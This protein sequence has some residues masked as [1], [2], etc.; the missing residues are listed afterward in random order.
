MTRDFAPTTETKL[1]QIFTNQKLLTADFWTIWHI[2]AGLGLLGGTFILA[3]GAFLT[4]FQ[5]FYH[6]NPHGSWLFAIVLPLWIFG[7]HCFDKLDELEKARRLKFS[8]AQRKS[9]ENIFT[10]FL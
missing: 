10:S 5:Y 8:S 3:C 7:A 1:P 2:G 4:I 9:S 6:E